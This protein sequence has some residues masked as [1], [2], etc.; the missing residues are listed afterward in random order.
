MLV[1]PFSTEV[2][3]TL[4]PTYQLLASEIT[5]LDSRIRDY[6]SNTMIMID[7]TKFLLRSS[8]TKF[9]K[10]LLDPEQAFSVRPL[11]F[12][13]MLLTMLPPGCGAMVGK[14][15]GWRD[16]GIICGVVLIADVIL[17]NELWCLDP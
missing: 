10:F 7:W 1:A 17:H 13:K 8:I 12:P 16:T 5:N 15:R 6:R 4:L 14:Y 3:E 9:D 2:K 11:T